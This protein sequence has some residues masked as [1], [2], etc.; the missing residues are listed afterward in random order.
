MESG[1]FYFSKK[2]IKKGGYTQARSLVGIT[3]GVQRLWQGALQ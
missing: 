3:P 1:R 2:E